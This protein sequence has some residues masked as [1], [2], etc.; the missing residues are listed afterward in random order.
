MA[1]RMTAEE[2]GLSGAAVVT[3]MVLLDGDGP[4]SGG[5]QC[6]ALCTQIS[7][8]MTMRVA[9]KAVVLPRVVE[10]TSAVMV[11]D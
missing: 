8:C 2:V 5:Y 9:A 3:A 4:K 1:A 7:S 6:R 11:G 10:W